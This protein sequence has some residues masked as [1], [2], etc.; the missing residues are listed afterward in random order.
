MAHDHSPNSTRRAVSPDSDPAEHWEE[1]YSGD[2]HPWSG[3]PNRL[4]VDHAPAVPE[5]GARALDIGCGSG[6]DAIWLAEQGWQTL[7][8]DLAESALAH[9]RTA[10]A[11]S[12][13]VDRLAWQRA[14]VNSEFPAGDWDLISASYLHSPVRLERITALRRAAAATRPGG[15]LLIIGHQGMPEWVQRRWEEEGLHDVS[16][17]TIPE[18]LADLELD[19]AEWTV[20]VDE[21]DT[22][23][24]SDPDGNPCERTDNVL[25]LRRH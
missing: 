17:P 1:F 6:A 7:G 9:A 10:A 14:D 16:L 15:V 22:I 3:K 20:E 12:A 5:A 19:P 24:M 25:R 23:A 21:V 13:A 8:V 11:E 2:E 4:L 18:L